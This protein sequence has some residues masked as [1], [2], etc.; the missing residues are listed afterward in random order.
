MLV[1][2]PSVF[3]VHR[4]YI[5]ATMMVGHTYLIFTLSVLTARITLC[6]IHFYLTVHS[7]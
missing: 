6:K 4:G 5:T 7:A 1:I 2:L 3:L